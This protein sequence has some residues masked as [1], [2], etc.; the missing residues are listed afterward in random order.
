MVVLLSLFRPKKT[1]NQTPAKSQIKPK[2]PASRPSN[3]NSPSPQR[4][5]VSRSRR[6]RLRQESRPNPTPQSLPNPA[7]GRSSSRSRRP[8]RVPTPNSKI[9]P[10]RREKKP[11]PPHPQNPAVAA[12]KPAKPRRRA[13]ATPLPLPP[14]LTWLL[15]PPMLYLLRLLIVGVGLG[16]IVG[17]LLSAWDAPLASTSEADSTAL[18]STQVVEDAV[19]SFLPLK[20]ESTVL[21]QKIEALAAQYTDLEVGAL[22][23][24][25]D[26]GLY[27]NIRGEESF[28]AASTIKLPIL[29]AFFQAID[30]NQVSLDEKLTMRPDLIAGEA[31]TM[32][33]QQPGTQF[34]A[35][36]TM[37][38]M[39]EISDNTATNIAIDRLGGATVLNQRFQDWGLQATVIQNLL[40]D[41]EGTN[42]T[43]PKDLAELMAM[44]NQGEI[45]SSR[46]RDRVLDIMQNVQTNS[47]LRQGIG[48]E[49]TIAHKTGNIG[50]LV[51]DAGIIDTPTGK[52][53]LAVVMVKRPHNDPKAIELIQEISRTAYE[54][55]NAPTP[56]ESPTTPDVTTTPI[57]TERESLATGNEI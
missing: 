19:Q 16:A 1:T 28:A 29:I 48:Q 44:M 21:K 31:G 18:Q 45:M 12:P 2:P 49:A 37:K 55:F 56:T 14:S 51:A 27:V 30:A 4:P 9:A 5:P 34:T 25:L 17:T 20:Q 39:I 53:Y 43:S 33:Y 3:R 41:V 40:P 26:T 7:I 32:Q 46:S 13:I 23:V 57:P 42:T 47:L 54:Y 22:L 50:S 38:K 6:S 24:D 10:L 15:S 11:N 35:L 52:R 8:Q 36:E